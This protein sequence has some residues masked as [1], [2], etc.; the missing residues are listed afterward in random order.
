MNLIS[1]FIEKVSQTVYNYTL[2][3]EASTL[4]KEWFPLWFHIQC[5]AVNV[6]SILQINV[7][8]IYKLNLKKKKIFRVVIVFSYK[9][10]LIV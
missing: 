9:M 5:N 4:T 7:K 3:L 2:L 6:S 1:H 10:K 8:A